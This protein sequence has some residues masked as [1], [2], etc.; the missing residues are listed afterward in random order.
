MRGRNVLGRSL[1]ENYHNGNVTPEQL[2][3][4]RS[5]GR[6]GDSELRVIDNE[7]QHVNPEEASLLDTWGAEAEPIVNALSAKTTNPETGLT[8]NPWW[9]IP[10]IIG[11]AAVVNEVVDYYEEEI[12]PGIAQGGANY[13][14]DLVDQAQAG[15]TAVTGGGGG[16][17]DPPFSDTEAPQNEMT[18]YVAPYESAKHQ[19]HNFYPERPMLG[20]NLLETIGSSYLPRQRQKSKPRMPGQTSGAYSF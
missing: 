7:L 13:A 18:P 6:F 15:G 5:K 19:D 10:I 3:E 16:I 17:V 20:G 2:E 1:L 8:E 9:W 14:G 11:G 12:I 4:I